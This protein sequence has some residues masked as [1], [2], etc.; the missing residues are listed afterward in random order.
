MFNFRSLLSHSYRKFLLPF[1]GLRSMI[2]LYVYTVPTF[3][4]AN[5]IFIWS[6]WKSILLI[7]IRKS[8]FDYRNYESL[9]VVDNFAG[10]FY[11]QREED[12]AVIPNW[13]RVEW[14]RE[15][16]IHHDDD[17]HNAV[18]SV[19]YKLGKGAKQW[20]QESCYGVSQC[21]WS[22]SHQQLSLPLWPWNL[23]FRYRRFVCVLLI[24]PLPVNF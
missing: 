1:L 24:F 16:T 14:R 7:S 19:D 20:G 12:E 17:H 18:V 9:G 8:F 23:S 22:Y 5:S 10:F 4:I 15:V 2:Q 13:R 21:I 3:F 6:N 11:L